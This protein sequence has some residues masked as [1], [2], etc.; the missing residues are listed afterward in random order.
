MPQPELIR[1]KT[2]TAKFTTLVDGTRRIYLDLVDAD[3]DAIIALLAT[4]APGILVEWAGVPITLMVNAKEKE[5]NDWTHS[6]SCRENE[7]S[8]LSVSG[9]S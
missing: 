5:E 2:T 6:Q 3:S 4:Q 9:P 8:S 1:I 7:R